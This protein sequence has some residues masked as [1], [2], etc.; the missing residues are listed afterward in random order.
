MSFRSGDT[1]LHP[2]ATNRPW[3]PKAAFLRTPENY[4]EL[5]RRVVVP[6]QVQETLMAGLSFE[7]VLAAAEDLLRHTG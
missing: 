2:T 4:G 5:V 6:G 7:A 3:G 1:S